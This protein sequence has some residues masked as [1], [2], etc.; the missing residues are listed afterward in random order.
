MTPDESGLV[1]STM[2]VDIKNVPPPAAQRIFDD[3][4]EKY[5]DVHWENLLGAAPKALCCVAQCFIAA[6][7]AGIIMQE[8]DTEIPKDLKTNLVNVSDLGIQA[9]KEAEDKMLNVASTI[10]TITEPF[11]IMDGIL[12]TIKDAV[13]DVATSSADLAEQLETLRELA[14][15]CTTDSGSVVKTFSEWQMLT[16]RVNSAFTEAHA[17]EAMI[18]GEI[19]TEMKKTEKLL[20]ESGMNGIK[21]T[22]KRFVGGGVQSPEEVRAELDNLRS[23]KTE[24]KQVLDILENCLDSLTDIKVHLEELNRFFDRLHKNIDDLNQNRVSTFGTD[25]NRLGAGA[26][27]RKIDAIYRDAFKIRLMYMHAQTKSSIYAKASRA[28]I[29]PGVKL[30]GDL[31]KNGGSTTTEKRQSVSNFF[32]ATEEKMKVFAAQ[33]P[34]KN[35]LTKQIEDQPKLEVMMFEL[36]LNSAQQ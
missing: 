15:A 34:P 24:K 14:A 29:M 35:Q 13:Q 30:I 33:L 22:L 36:S 9:F 17:N 31:C 4:M 23:K 10:G 6:E 25:A 18:D 11:G 12:D 26:T 3:V 28:H 8:R 19:E 27:K 2:Q 16:K 1:T 20:D 21:R 5:E 32:A 7:N